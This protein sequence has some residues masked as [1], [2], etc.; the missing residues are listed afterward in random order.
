MTHSYTMPE[1][2]QMATGP[3]ETEAQAR[4]TAA[5][6]EI[7]LWADLRQQQTLAAAGLPA[8]RG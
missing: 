4:E 8:C 7:Q 1:E 2:T 3:Y 6:Q 5:V